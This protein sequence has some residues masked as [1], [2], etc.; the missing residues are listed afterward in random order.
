MTIEKGQLLMGSLSAAPPRIHAVT[1]TSKL[2]SG[3]TKAWLVA[4]IDGAMVEGT[5]R[6]P[7]GEVTVPWR[8]LDLND[9]PAMIA[10]VAQAFEDYGGVPAGMRRDAA[11]RAIRAAFSGA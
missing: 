9:V 4:W 11:I 5:F 6:F 10:R 2:R 8:A 3:D 7:G 1:A